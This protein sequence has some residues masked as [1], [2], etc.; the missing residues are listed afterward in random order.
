MVEPARSPEAVP[1]NDDSPDREALRARVRALEAQVRHLEARGHA[2]PDERRRAE[3][4]LR[5]GDERVRLTLDAAALGIWE[6]DLA[7]GDFFMDPLARALYALP[8]VATTDAF[9]ARIHPD[10]L[11]RLAGEIGAAIDPA[12]RAPVSTEYRVVHPDGS[13]RWLR[14]QGRVEFTSGDADAPPVRGL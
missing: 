9:L 10:D 2:D 7:T 5:E 13:V 14:V 8:A 3:Q 11:D 12:R 4:A 6:N 1:P